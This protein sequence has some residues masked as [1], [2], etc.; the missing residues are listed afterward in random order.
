[1]LVNTAP[2]AAN[3]T[4]SNKPEQDTTIPVYIHYSDEIYTLTY[5]RSKCYDDNILEYVVVHSTSERYWGNMLGIRVTD[6]FLHISN[7]VCKI[8]QLKDNE[9]AQMNFKN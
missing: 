1:M 7:Y 6:L 2:K 9:L 5:R 8:K 4:I 3:I